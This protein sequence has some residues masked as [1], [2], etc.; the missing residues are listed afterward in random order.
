MKI[1]LK[2]FKKVK[3]T[4]DIAIKLIKRNISEP[5]LVL[6]EKQTKGRGTMGKKWIS[7]KGNLF[8][9]IFF[10]INQMKINFRQFSILNALVLK[11]TISKSILKKIKIKWPNDLLY[12]NRKFSGI[13][14]EVISYNQQ[15]YLIIGLG[16]NTNMDPQNKSFP[17]TSLK[18]IV[19]KKIDNKKILKNIK[20]GYEKFL[21][22]VKTNSFS[23]LKK[24][25][26]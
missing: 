22:E 1:N 4:N 26:R 8:I 20:K 14:Q 19:K 13:L 2:K 16:I 9:S 10:K 5:T 17:S 11:K 25:Y 3:S 12:K 23:E 18:N 24:K 15:N 21:N 7:Q 6:S